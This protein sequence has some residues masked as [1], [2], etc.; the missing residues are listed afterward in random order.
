MRQ[1]AA[2][3]KAVAGFDGPVTAGLAKAM[4][5]LAHFLVRRTGALLEAASPKP[6]GGSP[7]VRWPRGEMVVVTGGGP[8]VQVLDDEEEA[9]SGA[10]PKPA[11]V[12]LDLTGKGLDA[13]GLKR[14]LAT[15]DLSRLKSLNLYGKH[16]RASRFICV[17][18]L[19]WPSLAPWCG[20]GN[21][22][23]DKGAK[24]LGSM[25]GLT[26]LNLSSKH[27]TASRFLCVV[28]RWPSL[29][30]WCGADNKIGDEGAKWLG[31]MTGLTSLNLHCKHETFSRFISVVFLRCP[32]WPLGVV[33]TTR[34]AT[35]APSG[36]G[37]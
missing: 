37:A 9:Q 3:E 30:P 25:T 23:S 20:A 29:A 26:S 24:W 5:R 14:L 15:K 33:Q 16:A 11:P 7:A 13:E 36:S 32:L 21:N 34:L 1:V 10:S 8:E 27:E 19:C 31:S 2:C 22:I 17:V 18:F 28:L 35:R 12:A 4:A 6:G